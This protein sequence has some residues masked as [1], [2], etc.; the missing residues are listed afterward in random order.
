METK[1]YISRKHLGEQRYQDFD[2]FTYAELGG[3]LNSSFFFNLSRNL[4]S[5]KIGIEVF[6]LKDT[7]CYKKQLPHK[8]IKI[9]K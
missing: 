1:R 3:F 4:R 7:G 8:K 2:K 6:K 5:R 9:N